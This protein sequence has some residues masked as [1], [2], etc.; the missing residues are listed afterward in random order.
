MSDGSLAKSE[1]ILYQTEDGQTRVQCR[2][3][4][5]T[6]WLT[7]KLMAELFGKD[8]RT[9]S[10]HVQNI[11]EEGELVET[12][13]VRKFRIT[14]ADGK[15]YETQHLLLSVRIPHNRTWA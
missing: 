12:A 7:Q 5:E 4:N 15:S 6:V 11:F 2:F 10:E 8:V 3:E 9:I 1:I 14:A 13:V